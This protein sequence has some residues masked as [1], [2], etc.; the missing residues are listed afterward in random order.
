MDDARTAAA[1]LTRGAFRSI[2]TAPPAWERRPYLH[3][4]H[5][6]RGREIG[7]EP[8]A[9]AYADAVAGV[10]R[11]LIP[12]LAADGTLWVVCPD[13]PG[14]MPGAG[15]RGVSGLLADAMAG[16]GWMLRAGAVRR[17]EASGPDVDRVMLFARSQRHFFDASPM[18]GVGSLWIIP[19]DPQP[20]DAPFLTM[21]LELAE[22]LVLSGS[23]PGDLV[24]DPF[25]GAGTVALAAVAHGRGCALIE[26]DDRSAWVAR[27]RVS[28]ELE[29]LA[30]RAVAA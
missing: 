3:E 4:A 2:V 22:R 15:P 9:G 16:D 25:G 19:D 13:E 1:D 14:T 5:P 24:L 11:A 28:R 30:G 26:T 6:D 27:T 10:F 21:P 12:A 18:L 29:R 8:T 7:T 20:D 23:A 17:R